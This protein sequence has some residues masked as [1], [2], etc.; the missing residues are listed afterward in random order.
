MNKLSVT[1]LAL[2]AGSITTAAWAA[3]ELQRRVDAHPRGT[4]S[5]NNVSGS[6][7]V[8]GWSR[9]EVDVAA[10]L[11][12]EAGELIVERDGDR[13][14]I[15]VE[16]KDRRKRD[17]SSDLVIR[18]PEGSSIEVGGVSAD[19]EVGGVHGDQRLHTVSG[20]IVAE[21]HEGD[22]NM[23]TVSGDLEISGNGHDILARLSTTSG[24][25]DV[26]GLAGEIE[27]TAVSGSITIGPGRFEQVSANSVNGELELGV[28]LED[29]GRVDLET[30][31]GEVDINF[32]GPLSARFDVE[33]FNGG[34]RNCF[35][36]KVQ[37]NGFMR[38]EVLKFTEGT[39]EGRVTIRTLNGAI[40]ICRSE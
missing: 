11:G 29:D 36:P 22:V 25:I 40:R 32:I 37:S 12:W 9:N 15:E 16:D 30:I 34:I 2:L 21:V 13:V 23:E 20:D 24:D 4:V 33:T 38:G 14:R 27:A 5:I 8:L 7:E 10:D 1:A 6:V 17:V 26:N 31:N 28:E 39:G 35:G 19:I 18:L 3:N